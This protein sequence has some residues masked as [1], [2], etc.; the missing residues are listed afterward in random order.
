MNIKINNNVFINLIILY[1]N[2]KNNILY[3]FKKKLIF[4][5]FIFIY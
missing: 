4:N 3:K 1:K 2:F 5:Y